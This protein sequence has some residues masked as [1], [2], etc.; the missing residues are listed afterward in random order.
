MRRG[1]YFL[2]IVV[3]CIFLTKI[4]I[5]ANEEDFA[6]QYKSNV[7]VYEDSAVMSLQQTATYGETGYFFIRKVS[8]KKS[9]GNYTASFTIPGTN[10]S[11]RYFDLNGELTLTTL[12]EGEL[13]KASN[14]FLDT[15]AYHMILSQ[16]YV[17]QDLGAGTINGTECKSQSLR[18]KK[19]NGQWVVTYNF[20]LMKDKFGIIWGA[21]SAKPLIDFT[22]DFQVKSWKNYD[23]CNGSRL[24]IDGFYI[25]SPSSYKP[26]TTTSFW[27]IPS[28]Y[29]V[30]SMVKNVS[31]PA[32][33]LVGYSM[34]QIGRNNLNS[35]GFFPS[36]PQSDWLK[37]DYGIGSGFFDTRFNADMCI[38]YLCAYQKFKSPE[39][40]D[41]YL[42]T[43]A[44]YIDHATH[45][46]YS[47][48]NI[49]NEEGWLV[50]DYNAQSC[51]KT[52][53]ALNHQL[54]DIHAL[55][56]IYEEEKNQQY[57]DVANKLI[58]GIKNS[59]DLWIKKDYNLEYAYMPDGTMGLTDYPYLTYNDL[60][61]V[62]K[63]LIRIIGLRDPDLDKLM[64]AKKIWMDQKGISGYYQ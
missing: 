22:N 39:F 51:K 52:H 10:G 50:E 8:F 25:S 23:L 19:V 31:Y 36:L 18:V 12:K 11:V 2:F 14:I 6:S 49:N 1:I 32:N 53:V 35:Q 38:A 24:S 26:A 45:H 40:R 28:M 41:V 16:P 57:L 43:V 42:K 59:R 56:L 44:F 3:V 61:N 13:P 21:G 64:K 63:D 62:Q 33:D 37:K 34:M 29:A 30:T 20:K 9:N 17:Y 58:Q 55:L 5:T 15:D 54:Q 4:Q 46:H 60:F 47:N 27:R 48:V 7:K